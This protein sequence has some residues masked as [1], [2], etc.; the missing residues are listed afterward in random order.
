MITKNKT[1]T[2]F[3]QFEKIVKKYLPD[4]KSPTIQLYVLYKEQF[5]T[6]GVKALIGYVQYEETK[7][8]VKY[9]AGTLGHDLNGIGDEYLLPRSSSYYKYYKSPAI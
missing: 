2:L 3:D 4:W 7:G 8:D 6:K 9:I 5:N 1:L